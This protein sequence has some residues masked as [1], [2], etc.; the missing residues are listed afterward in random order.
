MMLIAPDARAGVVVLINPDAAGASELA[1]QLLEI[2]LGKTLVAIAAF[3][4]LRQGEL[5]GLDWTDYTG[6]NW[7][8]IV[9]FG[10]R[11]ST[12]PRR[13]PAGIPCR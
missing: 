12:F 5:R 10:C 9:P 6:S 8:S 11:W 13:G 4:G 3:A 1:S 7:R 2:V